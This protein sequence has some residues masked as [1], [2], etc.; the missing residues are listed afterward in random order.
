M[1]LFLLY[2]NSSSRRF[3]PLKDE[4]LSIAVSIGISRFVAYLIQLSQAQLSAN[5]SK[6]PMLLLLDEPCAGLSSRE[7]KSVM[8]TIRWIRSALG[9]TVI[10]I[11]HDMRLVHELADRVIVMH[12]GQVLTTGS[13]AEIQSDPLVQEVYV[14]VSV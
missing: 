11:E 5:Q 6:L 13:V 2:F 14:G 8:D 12:Q 9:I 1:F 10:V 7:T 4:R 3:T